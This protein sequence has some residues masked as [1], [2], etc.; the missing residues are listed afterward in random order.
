MAHDFAVQAANGLFDFAD[1]QGFTAR[2]METFYAGHPPTDDERAVLS[3]LAAHVGLIEGNPAMLEVGCGPTIHHVFPFLPHVAAIDMADYLP[4]NLDE[5]RRWQARAEGAY[6]WHQ[7]AA[8]AAH[9]RGADGPE[10]ALSIEEA[11]RHRIRALLH[12]DLK[13]AEILGP[14]QATYPVV[15]AFYCTEEV[16]ISVARWE[17]VMGHLSRVVAPGGLLFLSCLRD[18][19]F[20]LVG[21]R[22]YPCARVTEDDVR[23]VLPRL[24]FELDASIVEAVELSSQQDTGVMGVVLVA[25]RKGR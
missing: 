24:G 6:D 7:Y 17:A 1:A 14:R 18:T 3:F 5:V 11:A 2:Y 12:C 25:A 15:S 22:R 9:L 13:H 16:G 10:A 21:D 23:R 19:D 8:L 20:Y 4:G